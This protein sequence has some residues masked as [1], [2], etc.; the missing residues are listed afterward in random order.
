MLYPLKKKKSEELVRYHILGQE[1]LGASR[2][3]YSWLGVWA[4]SFSFSLG[5]GKEK[6]KGPGVGSIYI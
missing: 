6:D 4:L 5:S 3:I 1:T 2:Q